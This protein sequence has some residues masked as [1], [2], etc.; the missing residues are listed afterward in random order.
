VRI[1]LKAVNDETRRPRAHRSV[2]EGQLTLAA[3]NAELARPGNTARLAKGDGYYY[4][5][6]GEAAGW[7]DHAQ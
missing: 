4:F 6:F 7:L 1:T 5:Q 3:I 2:G